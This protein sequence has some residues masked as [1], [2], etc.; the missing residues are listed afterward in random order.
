M[1]TLGIESTAHTFGIGVCRGGRILSNSNDTY[2]P[3]K[4]GIVPR[5]AADHHVEVF[6]GVLE[7]AL[8]S[9]GISLADVDLIS[10]SQGPGI[11]APLSVGCIAAKA[12]ALKH[13]K[14]LIG[15]N[16]PYAH[17]KIAEH[18]TG[19]K[20][21]IIIYVSGG[22]T[23]ILIE[24]KEGFRVLGE[25]L[26]MGLGNMIDSFARAASL[27]YAH[28]SALE[29]LAKGGSYVELPY[30]VKGMNLSFSGLLTA[31]V[32]ALGS[33]SQRDVAHSLM[34]TSFSMCAEALERA[35][36]LTGRKSI[37][38]CGGV[39]QNKRLRKMLK[40]LAAED[41]VEFGAAPD[42]YNR[43]NGA[44]IAY[45]GE[46]LYKKAKRKT[47]PVEKWEIEPNQRIDSLKP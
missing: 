24:G 38:V 26:D 12:L 20:R 34:E 11:G 42:E 22:N 37:L 14:P 40:T 8:V 13:K 31:S 47:K 35:L 45:A 17:V 43:D 23:Q 46:L 6:P 3:R 16:H 41:G 21:P 36:F 15:V 2:K 25:T 32:R 28:G 39:A 30:T 7:S 10:F 33:H 5:K 9:A 44:M 29:K 4:E 18:L 27:D 1:I 19:L